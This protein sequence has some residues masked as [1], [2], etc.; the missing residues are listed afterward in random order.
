[1]TTI[2]DGG[3]TNAPGR[4]GPLA[5][6]RVLDVSALA[7]GP[8]ATMLLG[9][10]GADVITVEAP[11]SV[12]PGAV[13]G[14][15]PMY[16]GERAR[17]DGA[18]PLHRS[19]RS[20][21]L[22]LKK[23]AGL[24]VALALAATA[25]VF[26]E[27]FRP[28]ACARLGLGYDALSVVNPGLVYCSLTGYGQGGDLAQRAGHDLNYIAEAGLLSATTRPGQ[29]PG[30]PLNMAADYAAGG[31]LAAF[32]IL[33]ALTGRVASGRGTH[34]DVSMYEGLLGL[35][36][37]VPAWTRAGA[38]DPS[39]GGGL[40]SGA[41]PFYD[42]YRT[43]DDQWLSVGALEP[44]FFANLCSALDRPDLVASHT[45]P[46]RWDEVRAVFTET[47]AGAPLATWL[48]RLSA[49]DTAVAPVRSLPDAFATAYRR[50]VLPTPDTVGP[51]P[52]MSGWAVAPGPV[53][54]RPGTH[55][56]EVL[57]ELGRTAEQIDEL[58]AGGAVA[59]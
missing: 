17:R 29:R 30:I 2:G 41:V 53:V 27:G 28:G 48:E 55:T 36:Q 56:R 4:G 43:A 6:I 39:W 13:L 22:N 25:D 42:C 32:G 58:V 33:A 59:E 8:F 18:S 34:V 1:M 26:V 11:P 24:D 19:R 7:P 45:D 5:G 57:S 10:L 12:R 44:K 40:L 21:V 14:D 52:R 46:Q 15:L 31:L 38:P 50:G 20:I 54:T 3:D 35:L 51:I 37:V 47:F 49:V 9:D 23:S 16:G